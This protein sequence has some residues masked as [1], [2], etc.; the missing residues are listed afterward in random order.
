M[1]LVRFWGTRG[2]IPVPGEKTIKYGGNTPCVE[3]R[4]KDNDLII[5]DG[6]SGLR[7]LGNNLINNHEKVINIFIS[8]YHWDHIQG[9]PFFVPLY[10][11]SN[12]V[13][14]FGLSNSGVGIKK[15]LGNQMNPSNFP[16][17]FNELKAEI[18]FEEIKSNKKYKIGDIEITTLLVNHPAPALTY[19]LVENGKSIVYMTDNEIKINENSLDDPINIQNLNKEIL[20]FC[21][22][23]DYLIHDSMYEE[24]S[25]KNKRGWGHSSNITLA[26]FSILAEIKNLILFHYN[27]DYTDEKIDRLLLETKDFIHKKGSTL[28]CI[29]ASENLE[30]TV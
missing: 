27:P 17:D 28:S 19:K 20:D 11:S 22:G 23:A 26:N 8:H 5:L 24:S 21:H 29:A 16:I 3:V 2:S 15:L 13:T 14:F 18:N 4:S 7:E 1:M 25:I 9:I 6:G 30:I 12:N 10:N